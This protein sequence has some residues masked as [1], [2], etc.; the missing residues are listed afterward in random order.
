MYKK[1]FKYTYK[2]NQHSPSCFFK[3]WIKL[4]N[5]CKGSHKEIC[6]PNDF[7][8]RAVFA[9]EDFSLCI[10]IYTCT[11]KKTIM[12]LYHSPVLI[13]LRKFQCSYTKYIRKQALPLNNLIFFLLEEHFGQIFFKIVPVFLAKKIFKV[14][15]IYI[16]KENMPHLLVA[17][18]FNRS[19]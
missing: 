10:Y 14:L 8:I 19:T 9:Q 18:F 4:N 5:L 2:E 7:K 11:Y 13:K 15:T 17:M 12:V 16:Y 3:D 6:L 1:F